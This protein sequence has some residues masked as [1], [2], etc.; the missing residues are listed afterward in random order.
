MVR[1]VLVAAAV[2][3]LGVRTILRGQVVVGAV[4]VALAILLAVAALAWQRYLRT[5]IPVPAEPG[6][7]G[8]AMQAV[9]VAITIGFVVV[10]GATLLR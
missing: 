5:R 2:A 10:I 8:A 3:V 9:Q 1:G 4:A 6:P 7:A